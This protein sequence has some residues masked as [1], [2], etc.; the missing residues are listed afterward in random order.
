MRGIPASAPSYG[1]DFEL[2]ASSSAGLR[3]QAVSAA[4][5]VLRQ[6]RATL[7]MGIDN[8]PTLGDDAIAAILAALRRM[9][10]KGGTIRLRTHKSEH[11]SR[12]LLNGLGGV[13]ALA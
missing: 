3:A 10:E 12:L 9:C 8:L 13:V 4:Q 5:E 2:F 11:R 1:T 7:T 6:G